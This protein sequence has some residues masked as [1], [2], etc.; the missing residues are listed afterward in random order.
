MLPGARDAPVILQSSQIVRRT[1]A[2]NPMNSSIVKALVELCP[3]NPVCLRRDRRHAE[4]ACV[5]AI[6][7]GF[8]SPVK[9]G[10]LLG[11]GTTPATFGRTVD[12]FF[13]R[14]DNT[15][16]W[17]NA[18]A[19]GRLRA[20]GALK[21]CE[22]REE[23]DTGA[24]GKPDHE[25]LLFDHKRAVDF[26]GSARK[27]AVAIARRTREIRRS[28]RKMNNGTV[29]RLETNGAT[30]RVI[31]RISGDSNLQAHIVFGKS[32]LRTLVRNC[33][34]RFGAAGRGEVAQP[35]PPTG[36]AQRSAGGALVSQD[37]AA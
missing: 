18:S 31:R 7:A 9:H 35:V 8:A 16:L 36:L 34:E 28:L 1:H 22:R 23:D 26:V 30:S 5:G 24:A 21:T 4:P 27:D 20:L 14:A 2:R 29:C 13:G 6:D 17:M 11:Q 37:A 15:A 12:D 3:D 10:P 19:A 32:A 25:P 33:L